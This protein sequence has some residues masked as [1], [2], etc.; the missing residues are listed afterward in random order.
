ME[1]GTQKKEYEMKHIIIIQKMGNNFK[2]YIQDNVDK[3]GY[4]KTIK[5][6]IKQLVVSFKSYFS[7]NDI[8]DIRFEEIGVKDILK[9]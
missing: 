2:S 3:C 7:S 6:A 4:D 9:S 5:K 8:L 1:Y